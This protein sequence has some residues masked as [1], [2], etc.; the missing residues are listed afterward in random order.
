MR[1]LVPWARSGAEF[2]AVSSPPHGPTP[3]L[4]RAC[5][6][7]R[8]H[9]GRHRLCLARCHTDTHARIPFLGLQDPDL[10]DDSE[11][12]EEEEEDDG[13]QDVSQ[14]S[15]TYGLV[16]SPHHHG[17]DHE[18]PP[19]SPPAGLLAGLLAGILAGILAGLDHSPPAAAH[20]YRRST[21]VL[22]PMGLPTVLPPPPSE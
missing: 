10:R 5:V 18:V 1:I 6:W 9:D 17:S 7:C 19:A 14:P 13:S 3:W 16:L 21:L 22:S 15:Q 4:R 12:E 11:E 2:H 8:F 20:S